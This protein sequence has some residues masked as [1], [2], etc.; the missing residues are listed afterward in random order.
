MEGRDLARPAGGKCPALHRFLFLGTIR[1][2][3]IA[4]FFGL[5]SSEAEFMQ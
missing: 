1:D 5:K 3:G 4:Y 2:S